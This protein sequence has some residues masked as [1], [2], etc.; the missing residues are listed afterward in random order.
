M[1]TQPEKYTL[2]STSSAF[3]PDQAVVVVLSFWRDEI[4]RLMV[5]CH[6]FQHVT[7]N[8]PSA[9]RCYVAIKP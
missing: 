5:R 8:E 9:G 6:D 4:N 7:G 2:L 3:L 1:A